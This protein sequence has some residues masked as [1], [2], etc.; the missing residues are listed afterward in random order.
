MFRLS[1]GGRFWKF[2]SLFICFCLAEQA[3]GQVT[4]G[5][6]SGRLSDTSGAAIPAVTVTV[7]DTE[8]GAS[9]QVTTD[10][11]GNYRVLSLP[12]GH[13]E[14][15]A[16]KPGFK[17]VVRRGISL[18][19]AQEAVVDLQMQVGE[20]TQQVTVTAET[21]VVNTTTSQLS[22]LVGEQQVKDLPLNGRSFDNLITLNPGAINY[23]AL[24]GNAASGGG[25]NYFTVAGRRP[26]ENLFLLNGIE[27][28]GSTSIGITPG[29]VSGELLGIDAVREF[30]VLTDAYSAEYGKR[31]GAHVSVVTQ[32]GTNQLHGSVFE[33]VRNSAFDA[34]NFFDGGT[35]PP[36][37]RNQFGGSVGGPIKKE[38]AFFFVNYEGERQRLGLTD[39]VFVPDDQA[40]QGFL[41]IGPNNSLIQVPGLDRRMLPFMALW[42]EPNGP[43]LG[44]G[45]AQYSA[46]PKQSIREDFGTARFDQNVSQKDNVSVAD[47]FDDGRALTPFA[48]PLFGNNV[49][50]RAQVISVQETHSFSPSL[51]NTVRVGFSRSR[52][53]ENPSPL[54]P[55]PPNLEMM[56]GQEPGAFV[57]G[58]GTAAQA[59]ASSIVPAGVS[60]LQENV[61]N[62]RNL[63]T[64]QDDV[65]IIRG[66]HQFSFG[67]W[68]Q[69]MQV[70]ANSRDYQLGQATFASLT[71]FLQGQATLFT[72]APHATVMYWR[73][74]E[75]AWY[76]Q[77][78]LQLRPN[79]TLRLGLRHE[80]TDGWN[81]KYGRASQFLPDANG[82]L[83]N[84]PTV[85]K[86]AFPVN[87]ATKLFGPRVGIAYDP[88]G[89]GKTSIRAAFGMYYT[90]LDDLSFQLGVLPPFNAQ[91]SFAP[92]TLPDLIPVSSTTP[93]PPGCGPGVPKPCTTYAGRGVDAGA[94]TPTAVEW[95]F[96]IEHSLSQN[97]S[98]R[99]GYVGSHSYHNLVGVD[100]NSI[101]PQ[102]CSNAA[103][104]LAGGV[105]ATSKAVLV[106]AGTQYIPSLGPN[107]RPDPYLGNGFFWYTEGVSNYNALQVDLTKRISS[108]FTFRASYTFSKN[109]DDGSGLSSNEA[110]NQTQNIMNRF[111]P[112]RDY[113]RS[114]LD[115]E[116]QVSGNFSYQLP[117]G[118]G[119]RFLTGLHGVSGKLLSGWQ[120]NGILTLLSGFPVTP[121]VGSNQSG[122][123]DA[124]NPDR[125]NL[126]PIFPGNPLPQTVT[127]WFNAAAYSLPTA[128]TWGNVGRGVINGPGMADFDFSLFK[129]TPIRENKSL[130]FRA[131]FFNIANI[132]NLGVPNVAVF[133]AGK[134]N[135]SA[136]RITNTTTTSRQIQFGLKFMF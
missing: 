3:L 113:G 71:T 131:E 18:A 7:N 12:V 14:V 28:T 99:I 46:N 61:F 118:S 70:N 74:W 101:P 9:R 57:I 42:P 133:S 11:A 79:L 114:A 122:N 72:G 21:P 78:T 123:G 105:M 103:G 91:F 34:R 100:P 98:L 29:G 54:A 41:P 2:S 104:C 17:I 36:F 97:M 132:T 102:I 59:F 15:R 23:T 128:G 39:F 49:A 35:V 24:K 84:T 119:R 107:G 26:L 129:T 37:Q 116:H 6:I 130:E 108:G 69:R 53:F 32:S 13:Y 38:K 48:D 67:G 62:I 77:D 109:L 127:Q 125:P 33:F 43:D 94:K 25:G 112:L 89:N 20:V 22:G 124:R 75:S 51:I 111:D 88:F 52:F 10:E 64:L 5:S 8:T 92:A 81:E 58:G 1:W 85:G 60:G 135:P 87:N 106:P 126:N 56:Q 115:F 31:A 96:S 45:I 47:T 40:R 120:M 65:Q 82:V 55:V 90:L 68:A 110:T 66:K 16:E 63:F 44:G 76:A 86:S 30:N 93:L 27:Y 83:E 117:F 95:N 50:T 19:V 134:I 121:L 136:G 73:Q 80:F 4:G